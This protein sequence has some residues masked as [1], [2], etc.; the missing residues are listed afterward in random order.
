M[1]L[2]TYI[3]LFVGQRVLYLFICLFPNSLYLPK[4][5]IDKGSWY[6]DMLLFSIQCVNYNVPY[7]RAATE[8][9]NA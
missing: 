2:N 7:E 6:L 3:H 9:N 8:E 4:F 1:R 5:R